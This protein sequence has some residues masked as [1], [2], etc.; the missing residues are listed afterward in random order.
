MLSSSSRRRRVEDVSF[1]EELRIL[2]SA[3]EF[4]CLTALKFVGK[5][6]IDVTYM[7]YECD[8]KSIVAKNEFQLA[9]NDALLV[10]N[11]AVPSELIDIVVSFAYEM[12]DWKTEVERNLPQMRSKSDDNQLVPL[13]NT[14]AIEL[15][16]RWLKLHQVRREHFGR[17]EKKTLLRKMFA[18]GTTLEHVVRLLESNCWTTAMYY[19]KKLNNAKITVSMLF[20]GI[21]RHSTGNALHIFR[22][23]V[24]RWA[25][26]YK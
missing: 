16:S 22:L 6:H 7:K 12:S 14:N 13:R 23:Y 15:Y 3:N 2:E 20:T 19:Q 26:T 21:S 1:E 10:K 18:M 25:P 9:V 17:Q 8:D 5:Q 4:H 24:F 11:N